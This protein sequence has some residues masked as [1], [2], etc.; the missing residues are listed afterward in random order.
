MHNVIAKESNTKAVQASIEQ[1]DIKLPVAIKILERR[2]PLNQDELFDNDSDNGE[3]TTS[4]SLEDGSYMRKFFPSHGWFEGT[5][6]SINPTAEGCKCFCIRYLDGD[7]E[8]LSKEELNTA[9]NEAAIPFGKIGFQFIKKFNRVSF[10]GV[11]NQTLQ[12]DKRMFIFNNDKKHQY[13]I[14]QLEKY[15]KLKSSEHYYEEDKDEN[16]STYNISDDESNDGKSIKEVIAI[17]SDNDEVNAL[18]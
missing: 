10:S 18:N 12:S 9:M 5:I 14:N 1:Y 2:A 16:E 8:D 11:M 17:E 3:V 6:A 7:V 15:S 4:N 13:L